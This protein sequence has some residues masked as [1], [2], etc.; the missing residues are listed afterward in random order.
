METRSINEKVRRDKCFLT[1]IAIR[2]R[3]KK[4]RWC[5]YDR[6]TV[7]EHN[8]RDMWLRWKQEELTV[9]LLLNESWVHACVL[10]MTDICKKE[11]T[12]QG[13]KRKIRRCISKTGTRD[14]GWIYID[15]HLVE[16]PRTWCRHTKRSPDC[17]HCCIN[18]L[19]ESIYRRKKTLCKWLKYGLIHIGLFSSMMVS[20]NDAAIKKYIQ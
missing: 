20:N 6:I 14:D 19:I 1:A 9:G 2:I 11:A 7:K 13:K 17:L 15:F 18:D 16:H 10:Q 3:G 12:E 4:R 8:S 5:Y